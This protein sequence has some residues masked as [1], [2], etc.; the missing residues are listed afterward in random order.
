MSDSTK[1]IDEVEEEIRTICRK[2]KWTYSPELLE[3]F[4]K[5]YQKH[6]VS[7]KNKKDMANK[8]KGIEKFLDEEE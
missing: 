8:A 1:I 4:E 2:Q 5:Y 6:A 3:D 7:N